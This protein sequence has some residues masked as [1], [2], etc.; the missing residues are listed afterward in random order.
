R[1]RRAEAACGTSLARS[2]PVDTRALLRGGLAALVLASTPAPASEMAVR[3]PEGVLHG[4]L[5]LYDLSGRRIADGDLIQT[6]HAGHVTACLVFQFHDGSLHEETAVYSQNG[7]FHLIRDRLVQRGPSFPRPQE[8]S[9]EV[10]GGQVTARSGEPDGKVSVE[11]KHFDL[12]ADVANG[13]MLTLIKNIDPRSSGPT[14]VSMV[15]AASSPRLVHVVVT[16]D[17]EDVFA[18]GDSSRR[19]IRY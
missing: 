10:A 13:L 11:T 8:T 12:P 1:P 18:I 5:A 2:S 9:V 19:A 6:P 16:R 17:G 4:F 15:A 3:H 14:T 7:V